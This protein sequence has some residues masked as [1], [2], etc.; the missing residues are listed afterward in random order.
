MSAVHMFGAALLARLARLERTEIM[1]RVGIAALAAYPVVRFGLLAFSPRYGSTPLDEMLALA[2]L[3]L[4]IWTLQRGETL[5]R[6]IAAGFG[7]YALCGLVGALVYPNPGLPQP[8]A[9]LYDIALDA[10]LLVILFGVTAIF[11]EAKEPEKVLRRAVW[12]VIALALVNAPLVLRD[13]LFGGGTSLRGWPLLPRLGLFQ[14]Q[15]LVGHHLESLWLSFTAAMGAGYLARMTGRRAIMALAAALAVLVLAHLSVKESVALVVGLAIVLLG[16]PVTRASLTVRLPLAI[17]AAF[18]VWTL[19]P[20]GELTVRQLETYT[21]TAGRPTQVR[22]VLT[23]ES[24]A[25]AGDYFPLGSGAGSFASPPSFQ[26]GYS[27]VYVRH[28]LSGL[29]GASRNTGNHLLDV[30]WPKVIAQSGFA[31]AAFYLV[32]ILLMGRPAVRAYLETGTAEASL[33]VAMLISMLIIS[34]AATPF[35]H[36]WLAPVLA[37]TLAFHMALLRKPEAE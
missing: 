9:A 36:E 25:I 31:G 11:R 12:V 7:A 33:A 24:F 2:L 16:R 13:L 30:F 6:I 5:P 10:K 32:T 22:T 19:T 17:C 18:A 20:L 3:P 23:R 14:P 1:L 34:V 27:D 35:T 21:G 8:L 4:A 15:G 28:G 29:W 26:L 37:T